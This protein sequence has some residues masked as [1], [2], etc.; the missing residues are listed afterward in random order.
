MA[1]LK[2]FITADVDRY[3]APYGRTSLSFPRRSA[4]IATCNSEQFLADETGSRR[5]WLIPCKEKFDLARLSKFNAIQ[6]WKQIEVELK[7]YEYSNQHF[8]PFQR[9]FRLIDK[10]LEEL[11]KRNME[12]NRKVKAQ[13]EIE[14][15]ILE[16]E[17]HPNLYEWR[18]CTTT[19]FKAE[20]DSLKR[21]SSENIG[22]ALGALKIE[23]KA[24]RLNG[25]KSVSK[26]C[27]CLPFKISMLN[28]DFNEETIE[29]N[30]ED[31]A[32]Y[33]DEPF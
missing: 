5:F 6:L 3:R 14:D 17:M 7:Q 12:F 31:T 1:R 33:G 16:A 23:S 22:R 18:W 28:G 8:S 2:G 19:Q 10:E 24:M 4:F 27:R 32:L 20:H 21:Y 11:T 15:I 26:S 29:R 30:Q 13:T 25:S 9:S